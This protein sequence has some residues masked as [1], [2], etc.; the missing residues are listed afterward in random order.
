MSNMVAV[1]DDDGRTRDGEHFLGSRKKY[2]F[3]VDNQFSFVEALDRGTLP[4]LWITLPGEKKNCQHRVEVTHFVDK[5][6]CA[7]YCLGTCHAN[8][9]ARYVVARFRK[10]GAATGDPMSLTNEAHPDQIRIYNDLGEKEKE[11][12]LER[13]VAASSKWV[14]NISGPSSIRADNVYASE[15]HVFFGRPRDGLVLKGIA[16]QDFLVK[17]ASFFV[18]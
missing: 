16:G 9:A 5:K 13:H 2:V 8:M 7:F 1:Q 10:D 4:R 18:R 12:T 15:P 17:S 14:F 6:R 3:I 11:C